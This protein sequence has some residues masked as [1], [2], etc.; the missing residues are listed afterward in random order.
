MPAGIDLGNRAD[1]LR[2]EAGR[3]ATRMELAPLRAA[4][5]RRACELDLEQFVLGLRR[6][7][8]EPAAAV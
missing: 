6:E 4:L 7:A 1:Y 2:R 5:A 3:V 8:T